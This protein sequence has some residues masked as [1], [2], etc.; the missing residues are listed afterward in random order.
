MNSKRIEEIE[1]RVLQSTSLSLEDKA[2]LLK[3]LQALKTEA[4]SLEPTSAEATRKEF[5]KPATESS[6]ESM[7]EE[8][9]SSVQGLE[10]SH[11]RLTELVNRVSVVL[12]NMGI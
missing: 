12:S 6:T 8:L 4:A 9:T 11:P 3:D 7:I 2:A 10:A 5:A 1:S